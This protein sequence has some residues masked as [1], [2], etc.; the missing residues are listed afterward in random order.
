MGL[1]NP[2][3]KYL[4]YFRNQERD[5]QTDQKDIGDT[6]KVVVKPITE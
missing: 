5:S 6:V 3:R 4:L 2:R 1:K